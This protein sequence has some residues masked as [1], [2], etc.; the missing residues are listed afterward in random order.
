MC[1]VLLAKSVIDERMA[2]RETEVPGEEDLTHSHVFHP[3]IPNIVDSDHRK[4][5]KISLKLSL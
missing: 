1:S 2:K 3:Q 4:K 5:I